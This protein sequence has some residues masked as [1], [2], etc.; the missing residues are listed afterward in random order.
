MAFRSYDRTKVPAL[1]IVEA[2]I[3][4]ISAD[5]S[6]DDIAYDFDTG[7][8]R[9]RLLA[10][11]GRLADL[12]LSR[13]LLEDLRDNPSGPKAKYT[14]ELTSKL[15]AKILEAIEGAGLIAFGDEALK[16]LLLRFVVTEHKNSRT[17]HKY[18]AIGKDA[19]GQFEQWLKTDLLP[20]EKD[21]L[22]WS[23]GE[24]M[25]LRLIAPR[26]ND[27]VAPD[28]WA[29]ATERGIAAVEGKSF[30]EYEEMEVFISKGEVYTAYRAL[31]RIFQQARSKVVIIDP[32]MDEQVLDHVAELDASVNV[33]LVT[34]D[35]KGSFKIAYAKLIQQ[36]GNIEA[37][38]V[39][40][41]HDRFIVLDALAC[42]QLGSSINHL[43]S[44]ATVVDRKGDAV[45]DRVLA[46]VARIWPGAKSL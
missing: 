36:R 35:I 26:G 31:Q 23:W 24:L 18:N 44:K 4:A 13:E 43:G 27:L 34:E 41:F 38:T 2:R 25:R 33:Q 15:T 6:I 9:L 1:D 29:K 40:F 45:R 5:L 37:R 46:D 30:T 42:Y 12:D 21:T 11:N 10:K 14:L 22:I 17:V 28:E 20:D 16:Y 3:V 8:Y 19:P 7:T 32:Y 39:A